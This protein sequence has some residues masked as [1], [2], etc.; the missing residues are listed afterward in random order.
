MSWSINVQANARD[1][2]GA[3]ERARDQWIE[4]C[5]AF[6]SDE[7]KGQTRAAITAAEV[8][9]SSGSVGRQG[10]AVALSGHCEPG[11]LGGTISISVS[12][13]PEELAVIGEE[14][15]RPAADETS[16]GGTEPSIPGEDG[17]SPDDTAE[18]EGG[19]EPE[20]AGTSEPDG[21][22]EASEGADTDVP[23]PADEETP[24]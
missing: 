14:H 12:S 16:G 13:A 2:K 4:G 3:L 24:Q 23:P 19:Q 18:P 6:G 15:T 21:D 22:G 11:N 10:V 17:T 1:I 7:D 8:L 5:G 9:I 20:E